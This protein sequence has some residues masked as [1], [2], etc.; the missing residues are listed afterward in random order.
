MK[1]KAPKFIIDIKKQQCGHFTAYVKVDWGDEVSEI[2]CPH[3]FDTEKE[4][5]DEVSKIVSFVEKD[6]QKS[7]ALLSG[8]FKSK[9]QE[10]RNEYLH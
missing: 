3:H 2:M 10:K 1:L 8:G 7:Y 6:I 9:I 5:R 4:A